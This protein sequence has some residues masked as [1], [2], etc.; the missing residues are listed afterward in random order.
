MTRRSSRLISAYGTQEDDNAWH[1]DSVIVLLYDED[2]LPLTRSRLFILFARDGMWFGNE[3][4][5]QAWLSEARPRV[6]GVQDFL[7]RVDAK[8]P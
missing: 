1:L 8:A 5:H 6:P 7:N 4:G 3:H 2:T